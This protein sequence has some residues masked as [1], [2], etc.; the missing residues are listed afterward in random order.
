MQYSPSNTIYSD[1]SDNY[2]SI[3]APTPASIT[4]TSPNGAVSWQRGT[5]QIIAWASSSP[6]SVDITLSSTSNVFNG[7]SSLL[8]IGGQTGSTF[9]W[10]AGNW[11]DGITPI[12][13]DGNYTLWVCPTGKERVG[14]VCGS[15]NVSIYTSQPSITVT[16]PN[17]G[18]QWQ[19]GKTYQIQ[20]KSQGVDKVDIRVR[21]VSDSPVG[22]LVA[23]GVAGNLG[24][25]SWTISSAN[26]SPRNDY[27]VGISGVVDGK[28]IGNQSDNYFSI[29][30]PAVGLEDMSSQLASISSAIANLM[31]AIKQGLTQ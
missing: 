12:A 23:S 26:F 27:E 28:V 21:N 3:A 29:V 10:S 25:Y 1:R 22:V 30:A 31:E 11:K 9:S 5:S 18:E 24:T 17:G 13:P 14:S 20:W 16:S 19:I 7:S 4:V 6:T 15:F 2:F 8:I